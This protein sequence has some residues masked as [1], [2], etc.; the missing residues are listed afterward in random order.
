M[1]QTEQRRRELL[2]SVKALYSEKRSPPAIHPRYRNTYAGLYE[3]EKESGG[4]SGIRVIISCI[5]FVL[6]V[7][8]DH[9]GVEIAEVTSSMVTNAIEAEFETEFRLFGD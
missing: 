5:L 8:M 4:G 1:N 6:F 9:Q 2:E 7:M 3:D